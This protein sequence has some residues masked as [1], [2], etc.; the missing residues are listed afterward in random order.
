MGILSLKGIRKQYNGQEVLN[1]DSLTITKGEI[2]GYLGRNG[3]G[4]STTIKIIM[5]IIPAD[6]GTIEFQGKVIDYRDPS[7]KQYIGYC[8]DYPAVFE[9]LTLLEH[10]HFMAHLYGV[11]DFTLLKE[12]INKLLADFEMEK[13]RNTPIKQLSRGNKQKVAIIASVIHDP[14][15]LVY[16]EPTLGLDPVA[17]KKF[18]VFLKEFTNTGG[19]VFISSHLL[20]VLEEVADSVSIIKDGR[21]IKKNIPVQVI[22]STLTGMEEFL[23]AAVE[24]G[25]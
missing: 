13:Y 12:K 20:N 2:H 7:Y 23:L 16:D 10:L 15:L 8:P 25:D 3:A 14:L 1:I 17:L 11:K 21:I 19:T 18:K 5:G 4:K 22:H 6:E 24:E 9:N